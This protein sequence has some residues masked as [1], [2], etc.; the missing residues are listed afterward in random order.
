PNA[1]LRLMAA[2]MVGIDTGLRLAEL[3]QMQWPEIQFAPRAQ[4]WVPKE[5]AKSKKNRWVPLLARSAKLLRSMYDSA[6]E[7]GGGDAKKMVKW[8]F[9]NDT[10]DGPRVNFDKALRQFAGSYPNKKRDRR[11]DGPVVEAGLTPFSWHDL[12]RTC[13][14]R[15]LQGQRAYQP[16]SHPRL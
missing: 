15:L 13:G 8:V 1:R 2:V 11:I 6:L 9:P 12:R 14:C 5:R 16:G 3:R 4:V 7:A 10:N